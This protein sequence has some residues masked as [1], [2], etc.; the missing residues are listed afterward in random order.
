MYSNEPTPDGTLSVH[1]VKSSIFNEKNKVTEKNYFH[2]DSFDQKAENENSKI[3][4]YDHP[5][6]S[7]EKYENSDEDG[8]NLLRK[9]TNKDIQKKLSYHNDEE[10]NDEK[11]KLKTRRRSK[12]SQVMNEPLDLESEEKYK[13]ALKDP[14]NANIQDLKKDKRF[15]LFQYSK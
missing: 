1:E 8:K 15:S 13:Q 4:Y 5:N 14:H 10:Q 7:L 12:Y 3:E 11:D 2:P 9:D 6:E